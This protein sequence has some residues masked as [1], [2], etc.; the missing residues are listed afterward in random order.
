MSGLLIP[1]P[2]DGSDKIVSKNA[3]LFGHNSRKQLP[4]VHLFC[5]SPILFAIT[6]VN[7][8]FDILIISLRTYQGNFN[9]QKDINNIK[10]NNIGGQVLSDCHKEK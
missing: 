1:I 8:I 6:Y 9:C 3:A 2:A 5:G 10:Y 7:K 4:L